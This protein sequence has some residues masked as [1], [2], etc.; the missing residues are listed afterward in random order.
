MFQTLKSIIRGRNKILKD[1]NI[2]T[3]IENILKKNGPLIYNEEY[4]EIVKYY[5]L[6]YQPNIDLL[7]RDII[8]KIDDND[9]KSINYI[10]IE[11]NL[12]NLIYNINLEEEQEQEQEQEKEQEQNIN[13]HYNKGKSIFSHDCEYINYN[14]KDIKLTFTEFKKNVL[15]INNDIYILPN[16][17]T[18]VDT[19]NFKKNKDGILFV[20]IYEKL[21]LI[22]HYLLIEFN[23]YP[24]LNINFIIINEKDISE[25]MLNKFKQSLIYRILN[26][27]VKQ[28]LYNQI[29][30]NLILIYSNSRVNLYDGKKENPIEEYISYSIISNFK[31]LTNIQKQF[32]DNYILYYNNNYDLQSVSFKSNNQE[33][34]IKHDPKIISSIKKKYLKYKKKYLKLKK[35]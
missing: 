13:L 30:Y 2:Y 17:D 8:K 32:I 18:K 25:T 33:L 5:Y 26:S 23:E 1:T 3:N 28:I 22:P 35:I 20:Y 21:L 29:S 34:L 9:K 12:L 31:E 19:Y 16:Y 14:F 24:I 4:K 6:N 27:E 7:I 11:K 10:N 15:C